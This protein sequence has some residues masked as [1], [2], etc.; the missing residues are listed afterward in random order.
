MILQTIGSGTPFVWYHNGRPL[1]DG[2]KSAG[3]F[4]AVRIHLEQSNDETSEGKSWTSVTSRLEILRADQSDSGNYT[5]APYRGR[6]AS[7]SVFVSQG[8]LFSKETCKTLCVHKNNKVMPLFHGSSLAWGQGSAHSIDSIDR[9]FEREKEGSS[10][11]VY[12]SFRLLDRFF[13]S[14]FARKRGQIVF[15]AARFF[16]GARRQVTRL[17]RFRRLFLFADD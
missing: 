3:G 14:F 12:L 4:G 1:K 6:A 11:C 9:A 2:L 5:C 13:S 7:V 17:D 15:H 8:L 16:P 10:F